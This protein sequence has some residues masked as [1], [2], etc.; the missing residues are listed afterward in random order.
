MEMDAV[1]NWAEGW[2][3]AHGEQGSE[4]GKG[5]G[6]GLGSI[7]FTLR[8]VAQASRLRSEPERRRDACATTEQMP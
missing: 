1:V 5:S 7:L 6:S 2:Q 3:R 8:S 4:T